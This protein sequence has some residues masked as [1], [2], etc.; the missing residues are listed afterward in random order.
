MLNFAVVRKRGNKLVGIFNE[1]KLDDFDTRLY[2]VML[3]SVYHR[4]TNVSP[5][6]V[7]ECSVQVGKLVVKKLVPI[8][9]N[10]DLRDFGI[11]NGFYF[12]KTSLSDNQKLWMETNLT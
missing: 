12:L 8:F 5:L 6:A 4:I 10:T 1:S 3:E 7:I 2:D 11:V 9:I